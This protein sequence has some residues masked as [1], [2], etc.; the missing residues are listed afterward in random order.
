MQLLFRS[1]VRPVLT[2][3][4]PLREIGEPGEDYHRTGGTQR[5]PHRTPS[6]QP[7]SSLDECP[8]GTHRERAGGP[9]IKSHR[10][11][12]GKVRLSDGRCHDDCSPQQLARNGR[13]AAE[14]RRRGGKW[15]ATGRCR[16]KCDEK[17]KRT[18]KPRPPTPP[19][20]PCPPGYSR[21]G[22]KCIKTASR[23]EREREAARSP[24]PTP[25]KEPDFQQQR[26]RAEEIL[27]RAMDV[28]PETLLAAARE[29][30]P[31][32][33]V[34]AAFNPM[35][36]APPDL[37]YPSLSDALADP[38]YLQAAA[39]QDRSV[40]GT[41]SALG[42][43]GAPVVKA[44]EAGR[45]NL[46]SGV[47]NMLFNQDL[48]RAQYGLQRGQDAYNRLAGNWERWFRPTQQAQ[49]INLRAGGLALGSGDQALRAQNQG[50]QQWWAPVSQL[51][52][53]DQQSA[54]QQAGFGHAAD[55]QGRSFGHDRWRIGQN[56]L[57]SILGSIFGQQAPQV[58][59]PGW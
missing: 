42:I 22:G 20:K 37:P 47:A 9:C 34:S 35:V 49:D 14:C 31:A 28:T 12:P 30:D 53:F 56:N 45:R 21:H 59:A 13:N 50:W 48:S 25:A 41:A 55:M 2:A 18:E 58:A 44:T 51:R 39:E 8:P 26:Q 43:S 38:R 6:G 15:I 19:V 24:V 10:C 54:L 46:L 29:V 33:G 36:A 7:G 11:P 5:D 40:R 27:D 3:L 57:M 23:A 1:F 32:T 4:L 52:G 17:K 16:G